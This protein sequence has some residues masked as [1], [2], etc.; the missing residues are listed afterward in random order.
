[1]KPSMEQFYKEDQEL[2]VRRYA[3]MRS[4]I[5]EEDEKDP[6]ASESNYQE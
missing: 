3:Q 2:S 4:R 6:T 5:L 1:M